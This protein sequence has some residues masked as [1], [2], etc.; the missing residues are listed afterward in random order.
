MLKTE[1]L[2]KLCLSRRLLLDNIS[3]RGD[4]VGLIRSIAWVVCHLGELVGALLC[5]PPQNIRTHAPALI[6]TRTGEPSIKVK[7]IRPEANPRLF[8]Y[9]N[10]STIG[11]GFPLEILQRILPLIQP[12]CSLGYLFW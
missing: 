8:V 1:L 7:E 11:I 4:P 2:L 3:R 6:I 10:R 5:H 12:R 9:Q